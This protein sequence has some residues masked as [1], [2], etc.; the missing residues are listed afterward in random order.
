MTKCFHCGA[1]TSNGLALC[2]LCQRAASTYLEFLGVYFPNLARWRPGRAGGRP[3]PGSR[4]LYDGGIRG[5]GTGDRISDALDETNNAL[6][7][8]ARQ[9]VE[10]RPHLGR[11]LDRLVTARS[12]ERITEAE[13]VGWL[14][15]G[16]ERNLTSISTLD[17]CGDFV[18]ELAHH[19][20]VL[21]DL[22]ERYV[23]G[24]YAGGCRQVVAF[25]EAGAAV[26]CESGTYVVPG[27]TWVTCIACGTTTYARD[28]LETVLDEAREWVARPKAL[29]GALVALLDTE[30]S[31]TRLYDRIRRWSAD[32]ALMPIRRIVR[33]YAW[34]DDT[35][36]AVVVEV[37]DG[38]ARYRLGDV[39]ALVLGETTRAREITKIRDAS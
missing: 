29:A 11:L 3:V 21:R 23:P 38:P 28:H 34:D 26:R 22:T 8:R 14:C 25:D 15:K 33:D 30:Q 19:E 31:P 36:R 7:T 2:A 32:E 6:V 39:L 20:S 35:E 10:D 17:W 37:E 9:L 5:D 13:A 27:L 4:V 12:E 24:W 18:R 1:E 16:F